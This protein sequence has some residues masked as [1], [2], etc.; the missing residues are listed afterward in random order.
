MNSPWTTLRGR[1]LAKMTGGP[2]WP[3]VEQTLIEVTREFC[4]LTSGWREVCDPINTSAG[5]ADYDIRDVEHATVIGVRNV[6]IGSDRLDDEYAY[7]TPDVLRVLM[8]QH[9][10]QRSRTERVSYFDDALWL[11]PAPLAS[12]QTLAA[13]LVLQP[14]DDRDGLPRD[15]MERYGDT[16]AVGTRAALHLIPSRPWTDLAYGQHLRDQFIAECGRW[17]LYAETGGVPVIQ[18]N[19]PMYF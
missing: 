3:F 7:V 2:P 1:I 4:Q 19:A 18:R 6:V 5:I 10:G 11:W 14:T 17:R 9:P 8:K 13:T 16:L 15:L 12:G